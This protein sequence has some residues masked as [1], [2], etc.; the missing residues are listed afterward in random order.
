MV[1]T[2]NRVDSRMV[3][4]AEPVI[5][6]TPEYSRYNSSSMYDTLTNGPRVGS[7]VPKLVIQILPVFFN[8]RKL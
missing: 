8:V 5:S 6:F 7:S 2:D 3:H 4:L 1:R